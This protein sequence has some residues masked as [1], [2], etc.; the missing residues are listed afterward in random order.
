MSAELPRVVWV[1]G[2]RW[3]FLQLSKSGLKSRSTASARMSF[4]SAARSERWAW[5]EVSDDLLSSHS[6]LIAATSPSLHASLFLSSFPFCIPDTKYRAFFFSAASPC[7]EERKIEWNKKQTARCDAR[8]GQWP[9]TLKGAAFKTAG[10]VSFH[11]W[12]M[13][14]T[15]AQANIFHL[16]AT[17]VDTETYFSWAGVEAPISEMITLKWNISVK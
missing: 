7:V 10:P 8:F 11:V 16:A 15:R 17:G 1:K 5:L 3:H 12:W 2:T 4:S 14:W 9:P 13:K 6:K